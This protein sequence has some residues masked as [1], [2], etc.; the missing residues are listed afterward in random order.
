M[1]VKR[2]D[3]TSCP[4]FLISDS[5]SERS[6]TAS[7]STCF[8]QTLSAQIVNSSRY[9]SRRQLKTISTRYFTRARRVEIDPSN[10]YSGKKTTKMPFRPIH[11]LAF[12]IRKKERK[13]KE[14]FGRNAIDRTFGIQLFAEETTTI[15]RLIIGDHWP[16]LAGVDVIMHLTNRVF[17]DGDYF[18]DD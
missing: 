16:N 3:Q 5:I 1:L 15:N 4:L 9:L 14:R 2:T 17:L 11:R 18:R 6:E 13:K 7:L 12:A 8:E 10:R